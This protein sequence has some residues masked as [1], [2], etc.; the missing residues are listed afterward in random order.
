[1]INHVR[2]YRLHR[3]YSQTELAK[4]AGISRQYLW[5]IETGEAQPGIVIAARLAAL[6]AV[7]LSTLFELE[8]DDLRVNGEDA[9]DRHSQ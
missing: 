8:Q 4:K 1:M 5:K 3:G 2:R 7:P 6:L 9:G